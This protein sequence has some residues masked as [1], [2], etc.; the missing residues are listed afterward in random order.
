MKITNFI[1]CFVLMLS[2]SLAFA[3]GEHIALEK[4]N[5]D[6]GDRD[7]IVRGAKLFTQYCMSC[8]SAS[9]MRFS[10][11]AEDM[12]MTDEEVAE[13]LIR[14]GAKVG[15]TMTVTMQPEDAKRWFGNAPPDLSVVSR[16]RG[17][18]WLYTY[19]RSFYRD[20]T[21]PWGVNNAVF[22]DVAMPHV[23]WEL[24]GLQDIVTKTEKDHEGLERETI[25]GFKLVEKGQLSP[26]EFNATVHDLVTFLAY[27]GEP[28][29][30]QR[31][32]LGKWVL[33][34]L[35]VFLVVMYLLKKEY[36]KDIH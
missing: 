5:I 30:L 25:T 15:E 29:K 26:E 36:W 35:A 10:R 8:H 3:S 32:A 33:L 23:L 4:A 20:E 2:S 34:F 21:R 11:I 19:L 17:V 18:D 7:A 27:L 22:K 1:I 24:Q 28:S 13:Q 12:G 14:T 6:L 9:Y 16:A 31:L